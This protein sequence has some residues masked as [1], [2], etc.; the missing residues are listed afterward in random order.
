MSEQPVST[1]RAALT[2]EATEVM[3][4]LPP[5]TQGQQ[6]FLLAEF[7]YFRL[8]ILKFDSFEPMKGFML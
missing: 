5:L 2:T 8:N 1:N 4:P 6:V 7:M 3:F